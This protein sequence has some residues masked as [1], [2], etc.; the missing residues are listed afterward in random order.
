[1]TRSE[2]VDMIDFG[3]DIMFDLDKKSYSIIAVDDGCANIAEQVTENNEATFQS[4]KELLDN[5]RI[6]GETLNACFD[7]IKIT[8]CS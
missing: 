4:G 6:N 8:Y 5:Y 1:M 7:R 3:S 2:F